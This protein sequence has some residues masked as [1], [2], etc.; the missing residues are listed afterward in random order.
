V[1][2]VAASCAPSE[3]DFR[4]HQT[5][6]VLETA[7][8]FVGHPSFPQ[9]L[10]SVVSAA[11]EYWGGDWRDLAGRTITFTDGA[12]ECAGIP[13]AIGCY[14][15]SAMW[16]STRDPGVGTVACVEQTVVVHEVG[17][18]VIGD[19]MHHDPRWMQFESVGEAL[20]GRVGFT[21]AG[22]VA[23]DVALSV[24]RHPLHTS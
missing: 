6:I 20:A 21:E 8:P 12:A 10:E 15:G 7:A 24:W 18:A 17:H 2:L 14:D 1:A 4:L 23:C 3:I 13:N 22:E 5:G 19:P 16:I 11:L 9:R